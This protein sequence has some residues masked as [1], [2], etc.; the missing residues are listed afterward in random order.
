[1]KKWFSGL[2]AVV[3]VLSMGIFAHAVEFVAPFE[4]AGTEED[5]Y[6]IATVEDLTALSDEI[7]SEA[8]EQYYGAYFKQTADLDL[9]S[10]ENWVPIGYDDYNGYYF[11]GHYD[12]G[13]HW[14]KNMTSVNNVVEG[15]DDMFGSFFGII[16][17]ASVSNLH[18]I[19]ATCKAIPE[20]EGFMAGFAAGIAGAALVST[21]KNCSVV[22]SSF[23]ANH[24]KNNIHYAGG[25]VGW[26]YEDGCSMTACSAT[27]CIVT[28]GNWGYGGGIAAEYSADYY[29]SVMSMTDCYA[30]NCTVSAWE[31]TTARA[32]G[33]VFGEACC[34]MPLS[35]TFAYDCTVSDAATH[36]GTVYGEL[37]RYN[38]TG[39][40]LNAENVYYNAAEVPDED[41]EGTTFLSAEDFLTLEL[42]DAF[43]QGEKYP[44]LASAP[45]PSAENILGDLNESGALDTAD[46][47]LL[48]Q[49]LVGKDVECN[50][51]LADMNVDGEITVYDAVLLLREIAK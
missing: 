36:S 37:Y 5:P 51:D 1:M 14:I 17:E 33:G 4:G 29:E 13:N 27:D 20:G 21:F 34:T 44:V 19:N 10:V 2:I 9:S 35:N 22:H 7:N 43:V 28:V 32:L 30:A 31:N 18:I 40:V 6:I 3:L 48:L 25:I 42:G 15:D 16:Y 8:N 26:L 39:T 11:M 45:A 23:E 38:G 46:S 24:S 12:G 50:L 41:P 49:Y 47:V